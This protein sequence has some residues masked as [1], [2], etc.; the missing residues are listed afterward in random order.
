M[1]QSE[2]G[3][4]AATR[5]HACQHDA[6]HLDSN[7]ARISIGGRE[8]NEE[9]TAGGESRENPDAQAIR[10]NVYIVWG[11][12]LDKDAWDDIGKQDSALGD[13]WADKVK[14]SCE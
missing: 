8:A 9:H 13:V 10:H 5:A 11:R 6:N 14:S 7:S 1:G 12:G 3:E 4:F 2:E